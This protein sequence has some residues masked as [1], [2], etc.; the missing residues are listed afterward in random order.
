M[1]PIIHITFLAL[2]CLR[3]TLLIATNT[4]LLLISLRASSNAS[5]ETIDRNTCR[6]GHIQDPTTGTCRSLTRQEYAQYLEQQQQEEQEDD[7]LFDETDG[8]DLFGDESFDTD[9]MEDNEY[10]EEE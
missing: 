2:F 10:D 1:K 4:Y 3:S 5:A 7:E 6:E 9:M 8:E